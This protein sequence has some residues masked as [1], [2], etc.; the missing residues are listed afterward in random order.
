[1]SELP[2]ESLSDNQQEPDM[3]KVVPAPESESKLQVWLERIVDGDQNAL[4]LLYDCLLHQVYGLCLRMT[5]QPA[6]AEEVVQDTFWQVWRQAPRF[7]PERGSVKAWV[8]TIARSRAL[9]TLRATAAQRD[10][11]VHAEETEVNILE[12]IAAP[13]NDMPTNL[14]ASV[15]ENQQVQA[16]LA[17]LD[18]VIR[19]LVY[20][21]FFRG[22]SHEEIVACSGLPLGTVKSHIRRALQTL[23]PLLSSEIATY[24]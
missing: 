16:L 21:A 5:R 22:L 17:T 6:L 7:E 10:M 1:M 20:L 23:R 2:E 18:P 14:L 13:A 12:L 4:G 15:Q 19:Q 3:R 11:E 24:D 9:D 8:L